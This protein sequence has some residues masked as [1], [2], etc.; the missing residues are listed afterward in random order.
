MD[1]IFS[2]ADSDV[3]CTYGEIK[4]THERVPTPIATI[5]ESIR[6]PRSRP[7]LR[8]RTISRTPVTRQG[9]T[10]RYRTSLIA[11]YGSSVPKNF[12]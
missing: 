7:A 2:R 11:G 5:A 9:Y 12:V 1:T 10:A 8:W 4:N 6:L 3:S